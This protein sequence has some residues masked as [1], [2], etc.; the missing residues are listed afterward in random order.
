MYKSACRKFR[1]FLGVV[2]AAV[3]VLGV[4]SVAYGAEYIAQEGYMARITFNT[5]G[6]TRIASDYRYYEDSSVAYEIPLGTKASIEFTQARGISWVNEHMSN[7]PT[8]FTEEA[9]RFWQ[10]IFPA[11][12]EAQE[13][14]W[15]DTWFGTYLVISDWENRTDWTMTGENTGYFVF[16]TPGTFEIHGNKDGMIVVI[17]NEP[18]PPS[19]FPGLRFVIGQTDYTN[20]GQVQQS[21]AAPFIQDSRTMVPLRIIGEALGATDLDMTNQVVSFV[22]DGQTVSMTI[23]EPL[24][25]DMGTPV[26]VNGRTFVPLAYVAYIMD[27]QVRWDSAA[28]AAYVYTA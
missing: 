17:V 26:I 27:V 10:G 11:T 14:P 13:D 12:I 22:I 9:R 18:E 3:M 23:G 19:T 5:T 2:L 21:E 28:R 8:E 1:G 6:V 4:G 25:D 7:N 16:D 20:A 24:P 15:N